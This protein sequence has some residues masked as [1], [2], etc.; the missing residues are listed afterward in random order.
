[1]AK[2]QGISTLPYRMT[3]ADLYRALRGMLGDKTGKTVGNNTILSRNTRDDS[4]SLILHGTA[5][6]T[7]RADSI[8]LASDGWYTTTTK[9][10][11]NQLAG[12]VGYTVSQRGWEWTVNGQPFYDGI[13]FGAN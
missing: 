4:V 1:M 13:T 11:I 6:V 8:T 7:V 10:R 5:V 3:I 12:R 9:D 2:L